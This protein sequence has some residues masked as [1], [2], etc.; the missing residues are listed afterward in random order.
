[1]IGEQLTILM[2]M[3]K[4]VSRESERGWGQ[5][6]SIRKRSD[7]NI[8]ALWLPRTC[9]VLY[10]PS[11]DLLPNNKI[12]CAFLLLI[13]FL[14]CSSF[15]SLFY[16]FIC[17]VGVSIMCPWACM[18]ACLIVL[19]L[20]STPNVAEGRYIKGDPLKGYYDFIITGKSLC[21]IF[22]FCDKCVSILF[23]KKIQNE[24]KIVSKFEPG[25]FY[26]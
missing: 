10:Q 25:H 26:F 19:V 1:M 24:K 11:R 3:T 15:F 22:L 21:C 20:T 16:L 5:S 18:F 6:N 2:A 9:S 23:E 17:R 8:K 12:E 13:I 14:L 7:T 4:A